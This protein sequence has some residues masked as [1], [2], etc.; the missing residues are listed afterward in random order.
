MTGEVKLDE[1]AKLGYLDVKALSGRALRLLPLWDG[2]NWSHWFDGPDDQL[3]PIRIVG[4]AQ[5]LYVTNTKPASDTDLWIPLIELV[6]QRLSYRDLVGFTHALEDDFHLLATSAAKL[7]HFYA[8]RDS[9]SHGFI[10]SFVRAEVEYILIVARSIFDLLQE[11]ISRFWNNHVILRDEAKNCARTPLR[12]PVDPRDGG[13][14]RR[15]GAKGP[16]CRTRRLFGGSRDGL[17]L[18]ADLRA[19]MGQRLSRPRQ[20]SERRLVQGRGR[21]ECRRARSDP[22]L[23]R[24]VEND[25]ERERADAKLNSETIASRK[26]MTAANA[27]AHAASSPPDKAAPKSLVEATKSDGSQIARFF[28]L[29]KKKYER[30]LH[31]GFDCKEKPIRAHSIQNSK[32]LDLLQR[33]NHV[34]APL[35]YVDPATRPGVKFKSIG[36]NDASTFTGLCAKHDKELFRLADTEPL[37]T[38]NATQFAQLAYRA[39]MRELHACVEGAYRIDLL[40]QQHVRDGLVDEDTPSPSAIFWDKGWRV[41]RYRGTHFDKP[42]A[43]GKDPPLIHRIIELKEQ[44]PTLA[45]ASLFSVEIDS[46]GDIIGPALTVIPVDAEKTVAIVSFPKKQK[47]KVEEHLSALFA[48]TEPIDKKRELSRL[49]IECVENFVLGPAFHDAMPEDKEKRI[50]DAYGGLTKLENGADFDLF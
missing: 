9:L 15:L 41:I 20:P 6:W 32:V 33:D 45:A 38:S 44:T 50:I 49:I 18:L 36:R 43:A 10:A 48:A 14:I 34:V 4:T 40:H 29:R 35:P 46:K 26:A 12:T 47:S 28:D 24:M 42:M 7:E 1:L 39:V 11:V 27:D 3:L 30:C 2:E 25:R 8:V 16:A 21:K 13:R 31:V 17:G 23:R 22:H 5:S 37:D 19:R